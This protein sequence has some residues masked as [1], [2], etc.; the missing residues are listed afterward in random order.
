[1]LVLIICTSIALSGLIYSGS[2]TERIPVTVT[3]D[4]SGLMM[5][6]DSKVMLNGVQVGTV[7]GVGGT[8]Q[9][10]SLTL[11]LDADQ[12]QYIPANV[13]SRIRATTLFGSKFVDL[14]YP[15]NPTAGR[16][17]AGAV[18]KSSNVT[19]EV[20]TV[21]QN[22]V[23][24]LDQ[25]DPSKLNAVLTA[26][27][28][29]FRGNGERIGQA[30][31]AGNQV[32]AEVNSRSDTIGEDWRA[33]NR[34]SDA[35]AN[36]ADDIMAVLDAAATTSTTIGGNASALDALLLNT[37]GFA[38]A[39]VDLIA[40]NQQN[41]ADAIND[42]E[43]TTALLLKYSPMVTCTLLGVKWWLDRGGYKDNG[44]N[45]YSQ[46][47]DAGLLLG[48]DAY[49]YPENLAIVAAKGGPG[50][51]PGCGSLP[52]PSAMFPVRALVTNTGWGTGIDYRPNPGIARN[53]WRDYLPATRAIP[54][55]PSIR[56]CLPGPAP[57]PVTAPGMP[58]Y[59]A[60]LYG[61]GGQPL[62]P[63]IPP[64]GTPPPVP[65]PGTPVAPGKI[66]PNPPPPAVFSA[67]PPPTQPAGQG[68]P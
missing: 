6:P 48:D 62:W 54:E 15:A 50:G 67:P 18:L 35:Y 41:L 7:A 53:C 57:G 25:I 5:E 59:G 2:F 60:A 56:E 12:I 45:G 36:G 55:P 49:R 27:A 44:G 13:G 23:G 52:D 11:E 47:A 14:V 10:T 8:G 65:V 42:L 30:I 28:E 17:A 58:P 22:L 16:I 33:L 20:N 63:G 68:A 9:G 39:G 19:T 40:P 29:G 31:T 46:K 61:P 26:L 34:F 1:M 3:S 51:K 24:V 66:P 32:L 43:P 64:A 4:R 38:R 37:I 21:F